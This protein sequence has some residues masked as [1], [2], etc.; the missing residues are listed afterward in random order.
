MKTL[1]IKDGVVVGHGTASVPGVSITS[2][3]DGATSIEVD[4]TSPVDVGWTVAITNGVPSFTA[5]I[6]TSTYLLQITPPAFLLQ[7]TSQE[8]VAIRQA[9]ATDLIIDDFMQIVDDPRLK[10]IDLSLAATKGGIE[11]LIGKGIL[12]QDRADHILK[13]VEQP[14]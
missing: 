3:V 9:R 5:P 14:A 2:S 10:V 12:T 11:Y 6:P 13:G 7:F 4:D 1:F 8:R